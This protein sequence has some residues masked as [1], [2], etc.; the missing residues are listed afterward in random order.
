MRSN[1]LIILVS[2]I[3]I[4]LSLGSSLPIEEGSS[5]LLL[6]AERLRLDSASRQASSNGPLLM[7]QLKFQKRRMELDID[8]MES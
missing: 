6:R 2:F 7:R 8:E 5:P 4:A 3:L 1:C